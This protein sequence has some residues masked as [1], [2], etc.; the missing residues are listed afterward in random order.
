MTRRSRERNGTYGRSP[1][2]VLYPTASP[3][4]SNSLL[5]FPDVAPHKPFR[6]VSLMPHE[7]GIPEIPPG[8]GRAFRFTLP[9]AA[10]LSFRYMCIRPQPCA[11]TCR[12]FP[13]F[14]Y[15]IFKTM[16]HPQ[17][18]LLRGKREGA[19]VRTFGK[20]SGM[21]LGTLSTL[22]AMGRWREEGG[23]FMREN[24]QLLFVPW[25]STYISLVL[26]PE[27]GIDLRAFIPWLLAPFST[28]RT[29]HSER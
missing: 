14:F 17:Q 5:V 4:Y 21:S 23:G 13:S 25:S 10:F 29:D 22:N 27:L 15:F 20:L 2:N 26:Y 12:F 6:R 1:L 16:N 24:F 28:C 7:D 3:P 19:G 8:W 9:D 18:I 11:H